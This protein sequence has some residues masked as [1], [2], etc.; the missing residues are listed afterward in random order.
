MSILK[1]YTTFQ[2]SAE[3]DHC[4]LWCARE[5]LP[6]IS[7]ELV[8]STVAELRRLNGLEHVTLF[9]GEPGL[10]PELV[11]GLARAIRG[12]GVTVSV[13][14]NACWATDHARARAF[15]EP[16]FDIGVRVSLS[17]DAF[18]EPFVAPECVAIAAEMCEELGGNY[19]LAMPWVDFEKRDTEPDHRTAELLVWLKQRVPHMPGLHIW[20]EPVYFK[21]RPAYRLAHLVAKGHGVPEVVCDTTPWG[22]NGSQRS[23]AFLALDPEGYLS[24]ECG[25]VIGN[26]RRDSVQDVLEAFDPESHPVLATLIA[27]GPLGL[28]REAEEFGFTLKE[29]YADKCH[30]CEEARRALRP[31]YPEYLLPQQHY[32]EDSGHRSG[33]RWNTAPSEVNQ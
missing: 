32:A 27:S 21:G 8:V 26:V 24:K 3:C 19:C 33:Q 14:T 16:L 5:P 11:H 12:L 20:E 28:A 2:C 31:K 17:L 22:P 25:I 4:Y 15:L 6:A 18:H 13:E 1:V 7:H 9:G 23:L 29:D 30:L 10:V